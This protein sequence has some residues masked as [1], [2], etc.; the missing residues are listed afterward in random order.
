M[1]S[2]NFTHDISVAVPHT[3]L[4]FNDQ[5][6]LRVSNVLG[7]GQFLNGQCIDQLAIGVDCPSICLSMLVSL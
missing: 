6:C 5:K 4:V 1:V 7:G 2:L 3:H